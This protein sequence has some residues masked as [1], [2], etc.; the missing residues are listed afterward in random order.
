MERI[1]CGATQTLARTQ[2]PY[3][4][5]VTSVRS[6][7]NPFRLTVC[8]GRWS[9]APWSLPMVNAPAGTYTCVILSTLEGRVAP[10]GGSGDCVGA[11]VPAGGVSVAGGSVAARLVAPAV[12]LGVGVWFSTPV[13]DTTTGT[14]G[15]RRAAGVAEL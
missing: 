10:A 15:E 12:F 3:I 4:S 9:G 8:A 5:F 1:C 13:G 7:Q 14:V 6:I 2:A 11:C